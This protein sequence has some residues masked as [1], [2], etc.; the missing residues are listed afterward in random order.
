MHTGEPLCLDSIDHLLHQ[1]I[2]RPLVYV[3][4]EFARATRRQAIREPLNAHL[5]AV[6]GVVCPVQC[7]DIRMNDVVA[8]VLH[9]RENEIVGREIGG[10][11][12]GWVVTQDLRQR[13]F[14]QLHL[15]DD[16]GGVK[17]G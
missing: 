13:G 1:H 14:E 9:G 2:G 5:D 6:L 12:I 3:V 8:Q 11:H 17:S 16:A 7:I 15:V 10:A 4:A